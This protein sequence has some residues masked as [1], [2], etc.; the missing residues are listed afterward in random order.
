MPSVDHAAHLYFD[1][2]DV[3]ADVAR[4]TA[5]RRFLP[6][7]M[8]GLDRLPKFEDDSGSGFH[9]SQKRETKLV[10]RI[11]PWPFERKARL[12]QIG[13]NVVEVFANEMRK[14]EPIVKLGSP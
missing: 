10:M 11:E 9:R 5:R 8:P 12:R 1:P 14:H 6:E 4:A 13:E 7:D 3:E 2:L